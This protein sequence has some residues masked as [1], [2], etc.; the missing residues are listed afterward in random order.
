MY[1]EVLDVSCS[2]MAQGAP[3]DPCTVVIYGVA[4]D[5]GRTT[6]IPSL[7]GLHVQGLLPEPV[8]IIGVARR[9]W[10]DETF[11]QE[12]RRYVQ[13]KKYFRPDT[14]EQF[15]GCLHFVRGE[16]SA[17]PTEDYA[18]LRAAFEQI[19]AANHIPDN[20][21][22][23]L[24]TPPR[25]YGAIVHKLAAASLLGSEQGWRRVVIEKPFGHDEASARELD[26]QLLEVIDETQLYRLDH[27]LGKETVQ[28]MLVFRF[29]N[30]GF[31]PIW[32]ARYIDHVQITAAEEEGIGT[33]AGY[34]EGTGAVR[35][36][37]QNHLLQLL[38]MTAM[39]PP[40][41][42]D[43][44]SLRNET[45]KVLQAVHPLDLATDCVLGQY[46]AG[47][48][49]DGNWMPAYRD[50]ENVSP[51][52]TTPTFAAL[53][54]QLMNWRWEG[55]PFYLRTGKR[56]AQ[57]L[58][59]ITIQFKP[60]PHVMFPIA[61][62]GQLRCNSLTFRLQPGEGIIHTFLAKQPG[63]DIC[64]QPVRMHFRYD[65]AFGIETPP[66]AYEWLLHDAM[67]GNQTLFP[68]SDWIYKAWSLVDPLIK[69]W[70][71]NALSDLPLYAAG[72]W[73]PAAAD[74]LIERDGRAWHVV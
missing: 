43:G 22:F 50:E 74:A 24:S 4:G 65:H 62:H 49:E 71:S 38:C 40:V 29:A 41:F 67:Q 30:P 25:V 53:K 18:A 8:S 17:S 44:L 26:R 7:Y 55:V 5:L 21:L 69:R 73:G 72:S 68:R 59:E 14:W 36:M 39:E 45:F 31:E 61:D 51:A 23:H 27:Y 37:V 47:E 32:N 1:E 10:H 12:M 54:L 64:L 20:V 28:N 52:S 11:R 2:G 16:F 66:S 42:Y 19:R 35:D 13:D 34:Y 3:P 70:E 58:T 60:T 63:P 56:L 6:L 33:R 15:A 9:D 46:G 48:T 57:K